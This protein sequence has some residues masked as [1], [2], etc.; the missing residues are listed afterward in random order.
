VL[1]YITQ[2]VIISENFSDMR[3]PRY[4]DKWAVTFP[5]NIQYL[6]RL[7]PDWKAVT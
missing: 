4:I 6:Q 2:R 1:N 3:G 7:N 5:F